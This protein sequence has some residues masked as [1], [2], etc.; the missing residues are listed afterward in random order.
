MMDKIELKNH[1]NKISKD[2]RDENINKYP[3]PYVL[4]S[5]ASDLIQLLKTQ[6][7][8]ID[9]A[10]WM[11]SLVLSLEVFKTD[12][13]GELHHDYDER[14]VRYR[15]KWATKERKLSSIISEIR[16]KLLS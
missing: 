10:Q 2:L 5:S 13:I 1:I 6:Y 12:L 15:D 4:E 3:S 9:S 16:T 14:L 7:S 11:H 8:T